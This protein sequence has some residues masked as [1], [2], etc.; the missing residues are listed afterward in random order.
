MDAR[1]SVQVGVILAMAAMLAAIASLWPDARVPA[2]PAASLGIA[3]F[4]LTWGRGPVGLPTLAGLV[5][6]LSAVAGGVQ[7]A[8]LWGLSRLLR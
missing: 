6:A 1:T 2:W 4:A 5:G 8:A 3:A 7:I